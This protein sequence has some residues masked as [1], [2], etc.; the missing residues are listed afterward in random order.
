MTLVNSL[1]RWWRPRQEVRDPL[2]EMC[3]SY[4]DRIR[5]QACRKSGPGGRVG[6]LITP[7]QSTAVPLYSIECALMLAAAGC[8]VTVFYDATDLI[9]N[10]P[11][12]T[13]L[14]PLEKLLG[15]LPKS[16]LLIR[17][18]AAATAASESDVKRVEELFQVNAISRMRGEQMAASFLP[19]R[20]AAAEAIAG[21][22]G[23]V[24]QALEPCELDWLLLP[25]GIYGLSGIYVAVARERGLAFTTYDS[26]AGLL[27]LSHDC[28]A[29][30]LDDIPVALGL[31]EE[32]LGA[33]SP[34]RSQVLE[35]AERESQMR[36]QGKDD[37]NYQ[38]A[39][40]RGVQ[41][42]AYEI[43]IP[44]NV[45]WDSA[46]LQRQRLFPSV[47]SWLEAI[48]EWIAE[49]KDIAVCIRQHPV[50]RHAFGKSSDNYSPLLERFAGLGDRLRFVPAAEET[51][52]Y[53]LLETARVVLPHTSTVGVEAAMLGKPVLLSARTYYDGL[54]FTHAPVTVDEYF[55]AIASAL[56]GALEPSAEARERAALVYFLTQRCALLHS[57]FTPHPADFPNWIKIPAEDLW[58]R[59]ELADVREALLTRAPLPFIRAKRLL[60]NAG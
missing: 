57:A 45:R 22:F 42:R 7:W 19:D 9:E 35:A 18:S 59:P 13:H 12:P 30:H 3:A 60:G 48:L 31:L 4:A 8:E 28:V 40:A 34:I 33:G 41:T 49:R 46:A 1:K 38:V 53:D 29:A 32:W 14:E 15:S 11:A 17:V 27:R 2:A 54:G 58:E 47:E 36:R 24:R 51:S 44:L 16:I 5:E 43:L 56:A 52:T 25:G 20:P 21:H 39:A 50:E 10:S 23:C 37:L 26:G 6:V 55:V